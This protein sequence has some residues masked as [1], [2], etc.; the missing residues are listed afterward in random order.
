MRALALGQGWQAMRRF[1]WLT[2]R[3]LPITRLPAS[4]V[5]IRTAQGRHRRPAAH[6]ASH[7]TATQITLQAFAPDAGTAPASGSGATAAMKERMTMTGNHLNGHHRKALASIFRHPSSHNLEWHDVLSLLQHFG[8]ASER[9]GGGYDVAIG[10]DHLVLSQARGKDV[11]GDDL[12]H[13]RVFLTKAGLSAASLSALDT[14]KAG[15]DRLDGR[16]I[17]LIEHHKARLFWLGVEDGEHATARSIVPEDADGSLRRLEQRQSIDEHDGGHDPEDS[18]FCERIAAELN[19]ARNIV[20]FSDGKGRSNAGAYPIHYLKHL[21]PAI[22]GRVVASERVDVAQISDAGSSRP[23]SPSSYD[24]AGLM[25]PQRRAPLGSSV[26]LAHHRTTGRSPLGCQKAPGRRASGYCLFRGKQ[27]AA[28]AKLVKQPANGLVRYGKAPFAAPDSALRRGHA[29]ADVAGGMD[30]DAP[31]LGQRVLVIKAKHPPRSSVF[32]HVGV[33]RHKAALTR[34][35]GARPVG[36][37]LH[38]ATVRR[39]RPPAVGNKHA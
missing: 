21:H 9:N 5:G 2:Q 20:V 33:A 31:A 32:A 4:S 25:A 35:V 29:V 16:C 38:P 3:A 13:L 18:A 22:A 36:Q 24:G 37:L 23:L 11:S 14:I 8:T 26:R 19:A 27:Q 15:Q 1:R 39:V 28:G 34:G 17:A 7:G 6:C 30:D 10:D 12:R